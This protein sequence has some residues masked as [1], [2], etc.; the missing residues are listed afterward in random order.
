MTAKYVILRT[1]DGE[2]AVILD[3]GQWFHNH[4]LEVEPDAEPVAAGFV[5]L[6]T[7]GKLVCDGYS[8]GLGIASRG[9][10]DVAVIARMLTSEGR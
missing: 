1:K 4:A 9:E 2:R 5:S 3:G 8:Q 6:R 7:D 10:D